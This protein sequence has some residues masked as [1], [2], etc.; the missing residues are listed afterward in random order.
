MNESQEDVLLNE[1]NVI[2]RLEAFSGAENIN[3][4]VGLA[5]GKK[6]RFI[7]GIFEGCE[8]VVLAVE[9]ESDMVYINVTSIEASVRIKYPA[10]WCRLVEET[11]ERQQ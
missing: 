2:L 9:D 8:G 3:V 4:T 11:V 7:D 6:V 5:K 10:A 1:L